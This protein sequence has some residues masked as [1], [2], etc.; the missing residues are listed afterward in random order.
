MAKG[1]L[2]QQA[3]KPADGIPRSGKQ[4]ADAGFALGFLTGLV[5][6]ADLTK[7]LDILYS[8]TISITTALGRTIF[9]RYSYAYEQEHRH[10]LYLYYLLT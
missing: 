8:F 4:M 7:L 10:L 1:G 6:H 2:I 3:R 9:L 5:C